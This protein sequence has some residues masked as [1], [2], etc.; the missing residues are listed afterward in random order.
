MTD[1]ESRIKAVL[2]TS[3]VGI[4]MNV[5][6]A[7][8]KTAIGLLINSIAI[9][10]DG[11]NNFADATSSLITIIATFFA[12]KDPDKKHPFGYGRLEYLSSLAIGGLIF[13]AGIASFVEAVKAIIA[14]ETS[15]YSN[16]TLFI[17]AV[18]VVVKLLLGLYT[19]KKG[20]QVNSDA[21][22]ASGKDAMLDSIISLSTI[23]A[24]IIYI[25]AGISLEAWLAAIISILIMKAGV[26]TLK[27][28]VSKILGE[29]G[30]VHQ[31]IDVKKTIASF[32]GVNG[33]YDLVINDYGP[34]KTLASVH[35]E[36]D[37]NMSADDLDRLTRHITDKV[38]D[39][40]GVYLTAIGVYSKT[41]TDNEAIEL[42]RAIRKV[43]LECEMV[44]G[45]HGFYVNKEEKDIRFD[46]VISLA[47]GNRRVYYNKACETIKAL[48]PEY[49]FVVGM[50]MDF[51]EIYS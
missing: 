45:L 18:A 11:I 9:L 3:V 37:D 8:F 40:H 4:V 20:E 42:E 43:A 32:E 41:L 19:K 15:D 36:V 10:S 27:D 5:L 48:Y 44:K 16:V 2:K 17:V 26:E 46:L 49:S 13:Y 30:D 33:A 7:S 29:P 22:V 35:I 1:N 25:F 23:V 39:E 51:N 14:K 31:V 38:R 50:D 47:G 12:G 6:L 28:T 24:A 21:L 34:G